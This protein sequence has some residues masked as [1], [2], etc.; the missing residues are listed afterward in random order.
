MRMLEMFFGEVSRAA[1]G[2]RAGGGDDGNEWKWEGT[3]SES[4]GSFLRND[5]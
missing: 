5:G 4:K 1:M 2:A 3:V